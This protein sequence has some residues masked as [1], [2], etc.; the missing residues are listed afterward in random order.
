MVAD[1]SKDV[2]QQRQ[3]R[4]GVSAVVGPDIPDLRRNAASSVQMCG[5]AA[6]AMSPVAGKWTFPLSA[7]G[8]PGPIDDFSSALAS[9]FVGRWPGQHG[10]LANMFAPAPANFTQVS[11]GDAS[12]EDGSFVLDAA[13]SIG[14]AGPMPDGEDGT[15]RY[16][17]VMHAQHLFMRIDST[18]ETRLSALPEEVRLAN[19]FR[20]SALKNGSASVRGRLGVPVAAL[21]SEGASLA[22]IGKFLGTVWAVRLR[23]LASGDGWAGTTVTGSCVLTAVDSASWEGDGARGPARVLRWV[24]VDSGCVVQVNGVGKMQVVARG[25]VSSMVQG[26]VS[27]AAVAA[28]P[29]EALAAANDFNDSGHPNLRRVF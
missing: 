22:R 16:E 26:A 10:V 11:C 13:V 27:H 20:V 12:A 14:L 23:Q 7:M 18:G 9:G 8:L 29:A 5:A 15:A 3:A 25:F 4:L 6:V 17:V 24:N 19:T 1:V 2:V 21:C 28:T